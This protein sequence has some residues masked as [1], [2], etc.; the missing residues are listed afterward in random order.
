MS[1][2]NV[3]EQ[4]SP[5]SEYVKMLRLYRTRTVFWEYAWDYKLFILFVLRE[6]LFCFEGRVVEILD[7][8][9]GP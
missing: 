6:E 4:L 8:I 7:P 1:E 5:H 9:K 3:N 2:L